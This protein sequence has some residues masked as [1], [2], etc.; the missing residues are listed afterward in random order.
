[1]S[2]AFAV[3][4][5][6]AHLVLD[7]AAFAEKFARAPYK[8]GHRLVDHPLLQLPRLIELASWLPES[9]VEYNAGDLS[10]NQDP[11]LTPRNGLNIDE[12]I[13]R[14]EECRSWMVL[15]N[16]EQHPEYKALLDECLEQV[17]PLS[18]QVEPGMNQRE[19]FIFVS[20]PGSVTPY[21]LDPENNFLLQVR[22]TKQVHMFDAHDQVVVSDAEIENVLTG[23]HRNLPF[24]E[25]Y[26][27][28]GE[29]F[30]LVPGEG[31]HFPVAAPHYVKVGPEFSISFSITFRTDN[32]VVR[33]ALYRFNKNL[34][35]IGLRPTRVGMS[36]AVDR[37]KYNV[38]RAGRS[39]K[40]LLGRGEAPAEASSQY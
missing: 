8:I 34:R 28:R 39:V 29:L 27:V 36:P 37:C 12:T 20:S 15:K 38:I 33:H 13:R 19:G 11:K 26:R 1:M 14:I 9:R 21:H 24:K 3:A 22:G 30:D 17:R 32:S 23:G 4:A 40:R 16:V 35:R 7:P 10:I 31:L 5:T 2:T 25:E 18:E 6:P